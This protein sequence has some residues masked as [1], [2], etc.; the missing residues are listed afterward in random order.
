MRAS[1]RVSAALAV[2]KQSQLVA[3]D[4]AAAV[5]GHKRALRARGPSKQRVPQVGARGQRGA[6]VGGSYAFSLLRVFSF[7]WKQLAK[8]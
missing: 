2:R 3:V 6:Y 4:G 8:Q 1:S 5:R 7:F